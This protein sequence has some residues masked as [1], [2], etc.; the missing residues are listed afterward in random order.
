MKH[1]DWSFV[2]KNIKSEAL[3]DQDG[4]KRYSSNSTIEASYNGVKT[5]LIGE[6]ELK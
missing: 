4:Y 3:S 5:T 6:A 1:S 2:N